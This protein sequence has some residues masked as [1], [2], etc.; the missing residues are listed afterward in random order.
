V[1]I[2]A[3]A[4]PITVTIA[5]TIGLASA[6][7]HS[8]EPDGRCWSLLLLLLSWRVFH[9]LHPEEHQTLRCSQEH[10]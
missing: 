9:K 7:V 6:V 3:I 8:V 2:E 4:V 5:V 10:L 1:P